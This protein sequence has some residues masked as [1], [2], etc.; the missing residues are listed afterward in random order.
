MQRLGE[1]REEDVEFEL[2]RTKMR[3]SELSREEREENGSK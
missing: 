2:R 3:T 1:R